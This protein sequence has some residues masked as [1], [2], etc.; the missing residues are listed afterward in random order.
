VITLIISCEFLQIN[1]LISV[2]ICK[3][4]HEIIFYYLRHGRSTCFA[5]IVLE[6]IDIR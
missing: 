4:S 2:L 6:V 3:N 5:R 1:T